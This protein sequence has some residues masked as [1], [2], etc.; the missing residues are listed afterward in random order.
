MRKVKRLVLTC[1][2]AL[3]ILNASATGFAES[4]L[5][6]IDTTVQ[7]D[8]NAYE[9]GTPPDGMYVFIYHGSNPY[10]SLN[11]DLSQ[12]ILDRLYVYDEAQDIVVQVSDQCVST[13]TAT[14][15]ALFYITQTQELYKTDYDGSSHEL[16][17]MNNQSVLEALY[18]YLSILY[19]IENDSQI[20]FLDVTTKI[21]Q[22]VIFYE[23]IVWHFLLSETEIL[24]A[25][26]DGNHFLYEI[27][28]KKLI[29]IN[30]QEASAKMTKAISGYTCI[31]EADASMMA[32]TSS[33]SYTQVNDI[34]IPLLA[35]PAFADASTPSSW[36]HVN[37]LEGC[38]LEREEGSEIVVDRNQN[39][40]WYGGTRECEGFARFAHDAY[41]HLDQITD[42]EAW[43]ELKHPGE[44]CVFDED[45]VIIASFFSQMNTGAYIRYAKK[46]D[47]SSEDGM[48]S[49]FFLCENESESGIWVYECNQAYRDEGTG[50]IPDYYGCGVF[51]RVYS[52]LE[53][54]RR[55]DSIIHY[56]NHSFLGNW[57]YA[58]ASTHI[59]VCN[60]CNAYVKQ[61]HT[62]QACTF[63]SLTTHKKIYNCCGHTQWVSHNSNA[64]TVY[65][66]YSNAKHAVS[67][68]CCNGYY[69]QEHVYVGTSNPKCKLCG[70]VKDIDIVM[71]K[72]KIEDT[73]VQ[74]IC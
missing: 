52:Y 36:F 19:F 51:L 60:D 50:G 44:Q 66:I 29:S 38:H 12:C 25:T 55:Y 10:Y 63:S 13:Y 16:L 59:K 42:Y 23:N 68:S 53:V 47:T 2:I 56:V 5:D 3:I 22:P 58:D 17:Y 71:P 24:F 35:Y 57:T 41:Y 20:M 7:I 70:K 46:G 33:F 18:S 45:T 21:A 15:N 49:I 26:N 39:C 14:K 72:R 9:Y 67:F 62:S 65:S 1:V 74:E 64:Q 43:L 73:F 4:G 6:S 8:Y 28:D 11:I 54:A 40:K 30:Y 31:E 48:H 61:D 69:L 27:L 34:S 32:T 37:G